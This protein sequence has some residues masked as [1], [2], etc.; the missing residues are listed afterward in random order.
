MN[1]SYEGFLLI[2]LLVAMAIMS[3]VAIALA[4]YQ[5]RI[6]YIQKQAC[7]RMEAVS[8]GATYLDKILATKKLPLVTVE[9]NNMF[10]IRY[11]KIQ[12][13]FV[14]L[15][16]PQKIGIELPTFYQVIVHVTWNDMGQSHAIYLSCGIR[17][18][19]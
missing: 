15:N 8:L 16:L 13:P 2:E 18:V 1:R 6:I 3:G 12:V 14:S 11:E 7:K 9:E 5:S 19:V 10:T 4:Q 17:E